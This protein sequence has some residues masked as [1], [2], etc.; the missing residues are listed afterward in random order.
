[1]DSRDHAVA[2]GMQDCWGC[3]HLAATKEL[4]DQ[5]LGPVNYC[6]LG[7]AGCLIGISHDTQ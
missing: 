3:S 2:G 6:S 5:K 7:F 1:M 4:E